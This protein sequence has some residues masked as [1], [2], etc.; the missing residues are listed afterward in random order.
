MTHYPSWKLDNKPH[1]LFKVLA[2]VLLYVYQIKLLPTVKYYN[3][4]YI[5]L[6]EPAVKGWYLGQWHNPALL[7]E[8]DVKDEY[9]IEAILDS[10]IHHCKLQY[11]VK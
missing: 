10:K 4:Y 7:V 11:L 8:I 5:S 6:L 2:R 1:S 3:I 9:F